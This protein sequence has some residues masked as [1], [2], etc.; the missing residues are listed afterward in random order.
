MRFSDT[1]KLTFK[2]ALVTGG[3]GFIGSNLVDAI[4]ENGINVSVIDN[5]STGHLSNLS[6]VM[7][8]IAFI[9][10]DIQDA[11]ILNDIS[12]GCDV[13]FH[14]A[15]VVSVPQTVEHPVESSMV[16]DIG[17]LRVLE[18]ARKNGIKRV[19]MASSCA[20]YGDDPG[21]PKKETMPVKP[22]SPY[23]VQKL[24]GEYNAKLYTDLY[25]IETVCL[26]YF[27]VYGPR[28]DPSSP[29][30]GVISIF[31]KKAIERKA[32]FIYGDGN[33]YRDFVFVRDVVKANLKAAVAEKAAGRVFNI[34]TGQAIRVNDLWEMIRALAETDVTPEYKEPRKGDIK[35]SKADISLAKSLLRFEP[36]FPFE[37][38]IKETFRWY[39]NSQIYGD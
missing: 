32:P 10:G 26:R 1:L 31:M 6:K 7:D 39:Q 3:A 35:E 21:L 14:Q 23:A 19:V 34:G 37:T 25:G 36:S 24:T 22:L 20:V 2:K 30:S 18:A 11:D 16:N 27:N 8:R 12:K 29:Y 17:T 4:L 13:I 15:A 28:Q 5:L 9:E 38:G 33:Q